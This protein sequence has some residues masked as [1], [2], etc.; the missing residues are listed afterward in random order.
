MKNSVNTNLLILDEIFDSSLDVAGTDYFL[1]VMNQLGEN[2]NVFVI[3]HK[4]DVMVDKFKNNI[5]FEKT[6]DFSTVVQNS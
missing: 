1:S 2:S 3:S 4:G 5:R 6:N